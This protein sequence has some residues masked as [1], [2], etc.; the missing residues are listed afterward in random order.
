M[1]NVSHWNFAFSCSRESNNIYELLNCFIFLSFITWIHCEFVSRNVVRQNNQGSTG[2]WWKWILMK[3]RLVDII[4]FSPLAITHYLSYE[5]MHVLRDFSLIFLPLM[6][7]VFLPVFF[8][9]RFK[10]KGN[11]IFS[12]VVEFGVGAMFFLTFQSVLITT[13]IVSEILISL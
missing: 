5:Y 1:E 6:E 2:S 13:V 7:E 8:Y 9:R 3:V 10:E 11:I 4:F 12:T